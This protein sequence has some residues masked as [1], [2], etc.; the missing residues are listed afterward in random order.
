ME[1]E[2]VAAN[3]ETGESQLVEASGAAGHIEDLSTGAALEMMMMARGRR[4]ALVPRRLAGNGHRNRT[5]IVNKRVQ[6]SIH[7]RYAETGYIRGGQG[8][9]LRHAERAARLVDR[10]SD[11]ISLPGIPQH[12]EPPGTFCVY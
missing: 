5:T 6:S 4:A 10:A 8:Q 12:S 7:G 1:K 9:H 3:R 2:V 11:R